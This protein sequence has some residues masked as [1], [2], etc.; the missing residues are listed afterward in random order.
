MRVE[1]ERSH[2]SETS[3]LCSSSSSKR[4]RERGERE[5]FGE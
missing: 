5:D 1:R 4:S 2:L 3:M